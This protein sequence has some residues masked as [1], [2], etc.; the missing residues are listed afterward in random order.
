MAFRKLF[1]KNCDLKNQTILC[2]VD[3]NV[4]LTPDG[5]IDNN[6][7]IKA[8]LPTIEYILSVEGTKLI[9][10][11]HL[12]RPDGQVKPELTLAPVAVE[13]EKLLGGKAKVHFNKD[14][15]KAEEDVQKLGV[16]EILLL[17]NL[18]YYPQEEKNDAAFAQKLASYGT[19]YIN[20]A[21]GTA[22]RAHASTEGITKYFPGKCACGELMGLEVKYLDGACTQPTRPLVGILGGAKVS[23]KLNV[24]TNLVQK[25]DK[26]IIGGGMAYT[27]LKAQ[28]KEIGKSLLQADR[29][30]FCEDILKKYGD[31]I[32]LPIDAVCVETLDFKNRQCSE[33]SY[34]EMDA[35]P[36]TLE[37]VDIGPK[38][39]ELFSKTIREAKT[40]IWNGPMGVFEIE[41]LSKG[42][43][44]IAHALAEATAAGAITVVGGGDSA[45]AIKKSGEKVSH[46]S[47][48]GGA[49]LEYLEGKVLPGLEALTDC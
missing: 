34:H 29:I 19:F 41:A 44:A 5:K 36:A 37:C 8:C 47:T 6:N 28:G 27:F 26:L 3:F 35:I 31:K 13:L 2:R 11:S 10:M 38:T 33:P 49:S 24:V 32:L 43:F 7:R 14:C 9:L 4:P 30:S 40:V 48:G 18:R 12:G 39:V 46:V 16:H 45:S 23:D 21:F 22:H 42:T 1:Y 20:D 15:Q 17:E 25:C